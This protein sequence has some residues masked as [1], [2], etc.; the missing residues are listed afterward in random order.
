MEKV[1][2]IQY[3]QELEICE[4]WI[5]QINEDAFPQSLCRAVFCLM[6]LS[7]MSLHYF[8][9][10]LGYAWEKE[11]WL[12]CNSFLFIFIYCLFL[13]HFNK[14]FILFFYL[15]LIIFYFSYFHSKVRRMVRNNFLFRH[16]TRV[17][18]KKLFFILAPNRNMVQVLFMPPS[19]T[20]SSM[21]N[22]VWLTKSS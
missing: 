3:C 19:N 21:I 8:W 4:R 20:D 16:Y 14:L 18:S 7:S 6:S 17:N 22:L 11:Q 2:R 15:F 1:S 12:L 10:L 5:K 13:S 9:R